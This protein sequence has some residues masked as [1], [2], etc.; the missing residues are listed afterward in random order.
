[1]DA[2]QVRWILSAGFALAG[3]LIPA[4]TLAIVKNWAN[5]LGKESAERIAALEVRIAALEAKGTK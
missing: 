3:Y 1:M 4:G 2:E 5:I